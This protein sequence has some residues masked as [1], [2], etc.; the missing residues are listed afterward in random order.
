VWTH[1]WVFYSVPLVFMFVF[2]PV[3]CCFFIAMNL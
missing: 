1:V 2:V 3:L